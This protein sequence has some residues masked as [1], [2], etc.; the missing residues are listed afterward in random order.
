MEEFSM[1]YLLQNKQLFAILYIISIMCTIMF[2]EIVKK[3]DKNDKLK[4]YKVWLPFIFSC[5]FSVALKFIFKI[6][7]MIMIF[8][9]GSL[10]G[11]SVFG[12]E[13]IL[14]SISKLM[15]K[16]SEKIENI[17]ENIFEKSDK[18]KLTT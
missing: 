11:F 10:F 4:G 3:F 2:S 9:E 13:T 15:G 14:K 18:E 8:I 1:E 7:W 16:A 5:G 6:D 17:F 12:Y